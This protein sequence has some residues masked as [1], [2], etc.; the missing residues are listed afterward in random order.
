MPPATRVPVPPVRPGAPA[1]G[2]PVAAPG[3]AASPPPGPPVATPSTPEASTRPFALDALARWWPFLLIAIPLS[4]LLGLVRFMTSRGAGF[5]VSVWGAN[6]WADLLFVLGTV[7]A[8]WVSA[9]LAAAK[10]KPQL[11]RLVAAVAVAFVLHFLIYAASWGLAGNPGLGSDVPFLGI[12]FTAPTAADLLAA[13]PGL[14]GMS[15]YGPIIGLFVPPR[16][17]AK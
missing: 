1:P 4:S 14:A 16:P 3:P 2:H 7:G 12:G 10:G 8:V 6:L 13:A 11:G 17:L 15:F 9:Y 5:F